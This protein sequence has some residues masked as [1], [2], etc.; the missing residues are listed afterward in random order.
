MSIDSY[1]M[2]ASRLVPLATTELRPV[3]LHGLADRSR[4]A[5]LEALHQDERRVSDI[6]DTT[7]LTQ[8]NVSRHLACLWD[9]G[10]VAR[11]RRGREVYYRLVEGV[12]DLLSATDRVLVEAGDT[13]GACPRYGQR[14][15]AE[16]T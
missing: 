2:P 8:S 11:H 4:L 7:G 13:V 9:C 12:A 3:L 6:V 16:A 5:I 15:R 10:L 14:P 1:M